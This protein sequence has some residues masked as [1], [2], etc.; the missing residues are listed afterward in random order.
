MKTH[1]ATLWQLCLL[2]CAFVAAPFAIDPAQATDGGLDTSCDTLNRAYVNSRTT[3]YYSSDAYRVEQNG[4]RRRAFEIRVASA[5]SYQREPPKTEWFGIS[6]PPSSLLSPSGGPKFTSCKLLGNQLLSVGNTVRYSFD[7]HGLGSSAS[8]E[9]WVEAKTDRIVYLLRRFR[10]QSDVRPANMLEI[11]DY[12]P[13]RAITVAPVEGSA[14]PSSPPLSKSPEVDPTCSEVDKAYLLTRSASS[15]TETSY[16]VEESGKL[17]LH[18]ELRANYMGGSFKLAAGNKWIEQTRP[19]P[20]LLDSYA[21]RFDGCRP[22]RSRKEQG[23]SFRRYITRWHDFPYEAV[24]EVWIRPD[25]RIAKIAYRFL[26][27][28]WQLPTEKAQSIFSYP[29]L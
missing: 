8:G 10:P 5:S 29:E 15:Y 22:L 6:R 7:W 13:T 27:G 17:K 26:Q 21:P 28:R 24:A 9:A 16:R 23:I 4:T 20:E 18:S 2:L 3:P 25:G 1:P 11:F 19:L 14:A 12:D